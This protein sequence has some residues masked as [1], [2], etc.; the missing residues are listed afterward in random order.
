MGN[1]KLARI[2]L[3]H[4]VAVNVGRIDTGATPLYVAVDKENVTVVELLLD[5]ADV[6]LVTQP[7]GA[8]PLF[9]AVLRENL[10]FCCF[11]LLIF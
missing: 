11:I 8:T 6:N 9:A 3:N 2:L 10:V 4:N 1:L 7:I 5:L